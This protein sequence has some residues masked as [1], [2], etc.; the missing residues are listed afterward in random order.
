MRRTRGRNPLPHPDATPTRC[1]VVDKTSGGP[2]VVGTRVVRPMHFAPPAAL[3][4]SLATLALAVACS[5]PKSPTKPGG[6]TGVDDDAIAMQQ[7]SAELADSAAPSA[8]SPPEDT[9]GTMGVPN[10][11][12]PRFPNDRVITPDGDSASKRS[13]SPEEAERDGV[14]CYVAT[15]GTHTSW[16]CAR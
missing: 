13:A 8:S 7:A 1:G 5:A 2:L 3:L 16:C 12:D 11:C 10:L 15:R 4:F 9:D 14:A 6:P